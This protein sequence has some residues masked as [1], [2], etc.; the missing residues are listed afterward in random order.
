MKKAVIALG[1][2][3]V[4]A[5]GAIAGG[6]WYVEKKVRQQLTKTS[7]ELAAKGLNITYGDVSANV[8][9]HSWHVSDITLYGKQQ[10]PMVHLRQVGSDSLAFDSVPTSSTVTYSGI[11]LG[12]GLLQDAPADIK[13]T[14]AKLDI[15]GTQQ[16]HYDKDKGTF[17][18]ESDTVDA[19]LGHF[20]FTFDA[21]NANPLVNWALAFKKTHPQSIDSKDKQ[22]MRQLTMEV[23]PK[24]MDLKISQMSMSFADSGLVDMLM[25]I[26]G[27]QSGMTREQLQQQILSGVEH[28]PMLQAAHKKAIAEFLGGHHELVLAMKP[29]QPIQLAQL[30]DPKFKTR[31]KSPQQLMQFFGL[32]LNGTAL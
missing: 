21:D 28:N 1:T 11:R 32:S 26:K 19:N 31:F 10:Q 22:A 3:V 25:N 24:V 14:L 17:R 20:R 8:L 16:S 5:G 15:H 4:I 23:M 27:K 2:L 13:A 9:S 7:E 29:A 12:T 6:N 30:M 18:V